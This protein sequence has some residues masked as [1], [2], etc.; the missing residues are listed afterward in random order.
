MWID[1]NGLNYYGLGKTLADV[2][3]DAMDRL[4]ITPMGVVLAIAIG[5]ATDILLCLYY[6]IKDRNNKDEQFKG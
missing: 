5:L 1:Y 2:F 3:S 6:Y 4:G